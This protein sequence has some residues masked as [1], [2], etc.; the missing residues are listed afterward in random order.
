GKGTSAGWSL[1]VVYANAGEPLQH[2]ELQSGLAL[3]APRSGQNFEFTNFDSP[4][5]G[6]VHSSVG[7]IG[8]DG[9]AGTAGDA[10][11]VR[12]SGAT[13]VSDLVNDGNNIMNSSISTDG[14]R[15]PYLTGH[16]IGRS[17]N[18]FGIEADRFALTNAVDNSAAK[19]RVS[20]STTADTFYVPA[21]AMATELGKSELRLTKYISSITQGG[22]GS[23]VAVTA[24]DVL[25]YTIKVQSVG[26]AVATNISLSDVFPI[27]NLESV[28]TVTAGCAVASATLSC[29][30]L[31]D[32]SPLD[33]AITIS[34]T[35]EVK[36]GKGQFENFATATFGGNQ[37]DSTAFSNSVTAEYQKNSLDLGLQLR[38]SNSLIQSKESSTLEALIT[39]YG[40]VNDE[41]PRLRLTLPTGLNL[42]S[43]LPAGCTRSQN[44]IACEPQGLGIGAGESLAPGQTIVINF[45]LKNGL[46]KSKFR[47][48]GLATTGAP[49]GDANP[50]NNFATALLLV[51]HPPVATPIQIVANQNGSTVQRVIT[52]YISDPDF[53]SLQ[54]QIEKLPKTFGKLAL[55]GSS[56]NFLPPKHWHGNY[57]INYSVDD[58]K[59]GQS[60]SYISISVSPVDSVGP[61]HCRGLVRTGC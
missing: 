56:L 20:L 4:L 24:G 17:K 40:P 34:A 49:D 29:L 10:L 47:V 36:A 5:T 25:E 11:T 60:S 9:D 2:I 53:D 45:K 26:N 32:L 1:I 27:K 52:K 38:F 33:S 18:T 28:Q 61:Q 12:S 14:F 48:L 41:S 42:N 57:Q 58:G 54:I 50:E 16:S 22:S 13:L 3:I 55:R 39:N 8:I 7:L 21:V 15:N 43:N 23:N 37:G 46:E 44:K 31:G 35:A 51:N 59:G 30:N 19:V 6:S